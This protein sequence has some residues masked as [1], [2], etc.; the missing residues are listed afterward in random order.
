MK[1]VEALKI[2][3]KRKGKW[4]LP[5]KGTKDYREVLQIRSGGKPSKP[6]KDKGPEGDSE[7]DRRRIQ[8]FD[9]FAERIRKREKLR[10]NMKLARRIRGDN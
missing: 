6:S 9:Q 2:F 7:K 1:Y 5:K 8:A 3:N 4:C 10:K